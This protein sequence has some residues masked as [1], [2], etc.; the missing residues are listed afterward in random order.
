MIGRE[1]GQDNLNTTISLNNWMFQT[2]Y[3][4]YREK[5]PAVPQA[6]SDPTCEVTAPQLN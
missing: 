2:E 1:R 4:I 3:E 5:K 6:V